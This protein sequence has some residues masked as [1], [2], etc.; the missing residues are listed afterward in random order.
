[1]EEKDYSD[2][3][4]EL[5]SVIDGNDPGRSYVSDN[6]K[7][8]FNKNDPQR[9]MVILEFEIEDF[10]NLLD[11]ILSEPDSDKD[12]IIRTFN[13]GYGYHSESYEVYSWDSASDE[14]E[15]GYIFRYFD[16]KS[17]ELLKEIVNYSPT[18]LRMETLDDLKDVAQFLLSNEKDGR[19][20]DNIITEWQ[21]HY[22]SCVSETLKS[23]VEKD[24]DNLLLNY[25]IFE[26]SILTNYV[27]T[28]G[29]LLSLYDEY[30]SPND[31]IIDLMGKLIEKNSSYLGGYWDELYSIGCND[32]DSDGFNYYVQ[33]YLNKILDRY[34]EEISSNEDFDREK[35][36]RITN[37]IK[38]LKGVK[39]NG[40][41]W[42]EIPV[43]PNYVF[44]VKGVNYNSVTINLYKKN[45]KS[46]KEERNIKFDDFIPF[47]NNYKLFESKYKKNFI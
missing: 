3:Y 11:P 29:N 40:K 36:D 41:V 9:S 26:K 7:I 45:D 25:N 34:E 38:N 46:Y 37:Y 19:Y 16:D 28:A 13:R 20:I 18:P 22:N 43:M 32:F 33:M 17:T 15:E 14:F 30:G 31:S 4:T 21:D 35:Y 42:F 6:L 27:T 2:D 10:V 8:R 23:Q 44:T 5:K 47:M 1:M 39:H 24:F 12:F